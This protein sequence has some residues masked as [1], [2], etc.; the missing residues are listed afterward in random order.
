MKIG[1][2]GCGF[3]G[4]AG[5]FA[6]ALEGKANELILVDLNADLAAAHAEEAV[7]DIAAAVAEHLAT[8]LDELT[9][10]TRLWVDTWYDATLPYWLLDRTMANTSTLATTTCYRF[11]DGRFWAW[12]GVGCCQGT[13]T[14]VWGYV[15]ATGRLFPTLEKAL[16]EKV[17]YREGIAFYPASGAIS[18][19]GDAGGHRV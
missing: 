1:I 15:Q 14:H 10:T 8:N 18:F 4:S 17:D 2:V 13:C 19:R 9:A 12:E 5:A 11:E 6:I 3:V 7:A 16:R